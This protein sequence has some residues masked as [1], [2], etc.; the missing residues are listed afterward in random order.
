MEHMKKRMQ[1]CAGLGAPDDYA[2]LAAKV[3]ESFM[4][5]FWRED[6]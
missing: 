6:R 3:Q 5:A 4:S 1:I 2:A